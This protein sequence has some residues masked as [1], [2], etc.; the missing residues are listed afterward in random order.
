MVRIIDSKVADIRSN[1]TY[2]E[3]AGLSTDAKPT[4]GV[5]TGSVFVEVNTGKAFLFAEPSTWTEVQ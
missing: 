4:D 5:S 1:K 2:Y 3:F